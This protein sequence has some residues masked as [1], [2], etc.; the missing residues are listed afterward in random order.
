MS[1]VVLALA[2]CAHHPVEVDE[3][4]PGAAAVPIPEPAKPA[5]IIE[6]PQ[7]LPLP[8]QLKFA[9]S[10]AASGTT[11][12]ESAD[13]KTR[14]NLANGAARIEPL[15]SSYVNATQVWPYSEGA[16]YQVYT[17]PTRVTDIAL[18]AGETLIDVSA[19]DT[20]R[21]IIGDTRSGVGA[22]Q[23]AHITLK[24]TR[25]DLKSN[26]A[27]FTDRRVYYLELQATPETWMASVSWEYPRDRLVTLKAAQTV[28]ETQTPVASGVALERL[29]FRYEVSGDS[30]DWR[31]VR[32]FDDGAKVYIQFPAGIA[33]MEMP[34][35]FIIGAGGDT[36]L[37]NYRVHAPYYIV[38][39]LFAAAELR[40]GGKHAQ[41][42]RIVRQDAKTRVHRR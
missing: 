21:W 42:V 28:A 23:R 2:G 12:T 3:P 27:I 18:E 37:V 19:P 15:R 13:P 35:L 25:A 1:L 10:L 7:A 9:P 16:L 29:N 38:D 32:A 34:P 17:S 24:P 5:I 4:E 36:E 31:P 14:V 22:N 41:R 8:G 20:V 40:F 11:A 6:T 26:L 33:Q 30:P 39:R